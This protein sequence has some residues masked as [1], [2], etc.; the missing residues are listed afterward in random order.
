ME[1]PTLLVV[2][3]DV[4]SGGLRS[5]LTSEPLLRAICFVLTLR[6]CLLILLALLRPRRCRLLRIGHTARPGVLPR[7]GLH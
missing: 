5:F 2:R 1:V 4:K 7:I 3:H 6:V